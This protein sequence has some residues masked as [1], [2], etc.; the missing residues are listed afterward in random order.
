MVPK[1]RRQK[2]PDTPGVE[3]DIQLKSK[4]Q[5]DVEPKPKRQR[6]HNE[7]QQSSVQ[8]LSRLDIARMLGCTVDRVRKFEKTGQLTPY[9]WGHKMIRYAVADVHKLIEGGRGGR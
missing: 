8:F 5:K 6:Q 4:T 7:R 9:H 1:S 3:L 2:E